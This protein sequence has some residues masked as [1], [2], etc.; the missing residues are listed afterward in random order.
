MC[1]EL[2]RIYLDFV[3]GG[4]AD[5]LVPV[6]QHNQWIFADCDSRPHPVTLGDEG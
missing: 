6:F 1:I 3:R 5:P 4:H 2:I